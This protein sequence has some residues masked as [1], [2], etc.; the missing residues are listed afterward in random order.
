MVTMALQEA[1]KLEA[2]LL[3]ALNKNHLFDTS[4]H[5]K[6]QETILENLI[7]R[8]NDHYNAQ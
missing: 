2:V 1:H 7:K 8:Y 6:V 3:A 5:F 4:L